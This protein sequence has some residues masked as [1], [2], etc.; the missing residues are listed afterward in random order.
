MR[1]GDPPAHLGLAFA[2]LL[3]EPVRNEGPLET[4][5]GHGEC[6]KSGGW[7]GGWGG[8]GGWGGMLWGRKWSSKGLDETVRRKD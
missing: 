6:G 4:G 8:I 1:S 5:K 2:S 7:W 3:G